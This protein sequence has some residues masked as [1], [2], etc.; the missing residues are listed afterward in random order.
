MSVECN[1]M[2]RVKH[3][4]AESNCWKVSWTGA[5]WDREEWSLIQPS[6]NHKRTDMYSLTHSPTH[7]HTN[8]GTGE[9]KHIKRDSKFRSYSTLGITLASSW[10][11]PAKPKPSAI[12]QFSRSYDF[13]QGAY[14]RSSRVS[15]TPQTGPSI[16]FWWGFSPVCRACF[17]FSL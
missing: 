13:F 1:H 17:L 5:K 7:W 9:E 16:L 2:R 4:K 10:Y 15:R 12:S 8:G 3:L 14:S 11:N 6:I